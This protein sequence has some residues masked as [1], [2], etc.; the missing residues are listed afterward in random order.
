MAGQINSSAGTVNARGTIL[1][2]NPN[3]IMVTASGVI[4]AGSFV[5]STFEIAD[6][7]VLSG[8]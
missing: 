2:V 3:G 7:D 4:N 1:L 5:A 8:K 6:K